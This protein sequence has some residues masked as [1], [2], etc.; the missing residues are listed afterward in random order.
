[1]GGLVTGDGLSRPTIPNKKGV[2]AM[3][4]STR[5]FWLLA[6]SIGLLMLPAA[7]FATNIADTQMKFPI[8]LSVT[9][10]CNGE[11]VDFTGELHVHSHATLN[12]DGSTSYA[13]DINYSDA[14][15]VGETTGLSY[16]FGSN[17]H[18]ITTY[19]A[20]S[21]S[22]YTYTQRQTSKL[23]SPGAD[24]NQHFTFLLDYVLDAS[25]FHITLYDFE[26]RCN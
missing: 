24:P 15:G 20:G 19:P 10:E 2:S 7:T 21:T 16:V 17:A 25:G 9:N 3:A 11:L 12:K 18:T 4:R 6:V 13:T 5:L 22:F 8:S 14:K 1:M 23:V 26:L